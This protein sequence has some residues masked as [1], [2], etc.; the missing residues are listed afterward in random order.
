MKNLL[1]L[2]GTMHIGGAENV[3]S[4]LAHNINPELFNIT[5]CYINQGGAVKEELLRDGYY[6][7]NLPR[8][9]NSWAKYFTAWMLRQLVKEK[10]IDIIHS[11]D[12]ASFFDAAICRLISPKLKHIHT[13]HYGNYPHRPPKYLLMEKLLWRIPDR[14]LAVGNSQKLVIQKT[15]SMKDKYIKTI[16]NG[17]DEPKC[18]SNE[19]LNKTRINKN[20]ILIGSISTLIPQKAIHELLEVIARLKKIRNDFEVVIVGH[21][22]LREELENK[23][24]ELNIENLIQWMG[25]VENASGTVLPN[26]DVFVQTSH[27]EAMSVVIL[28]AMA[29]GKA[30]IATDVGDNKVVI[31]DNKTGVIVK[32]GDVDGFFTKLNELLDDQV[33]RKIL[34]DAAYS[35]Y[36]EKFTAPTMTRAYEKVYLETFD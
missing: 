36:K 3:I 6:V 28:E 12:L 23:A 20:N 19:L 4:T 30:I 5:I 22:V 2:N 26:L 10:N 11:H 27:W 7:I 16:W 18:E 34:G 14:L 9:N 24:K 33:R 31:E 8:S 25:W 21:G 15:F 13:F 32:A 1:L 17:I 29:S 35:S